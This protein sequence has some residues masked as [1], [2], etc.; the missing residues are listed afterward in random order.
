MAEVEVVIGETVFVVTLDQDEAV[1]LRDMLFGFGDG[2][3]YELY[4]ALDAEL[5]GKRGGE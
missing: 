1:Q 5:G 3:M 4:K 2:E